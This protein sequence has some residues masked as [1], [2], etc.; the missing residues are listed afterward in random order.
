M[1]R[2]SARLLILLVALLLAAA[3]PLPLPPELNDTTTTERWIWEHMKAGEV[4]DLNA[5][6]VSGPPESG[7]LPKRG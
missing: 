7:G 6:A 1:V 3:S 4:A 2:H 5:R